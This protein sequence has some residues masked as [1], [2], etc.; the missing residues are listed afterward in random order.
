MTELI[1]FQKYADCIT[2]SGKYLFHNMTVDQLHYFIMNAEDYIP[3]N[4]INMNKLS[5]KN[6]HS[7]KTFTYRSFSADADVVLKSQTIENGKQVFI[8]NYVN[9]LMLG[10]ST[11]DMVW[12]IENAGANKT[13]LTCSGKIVISGIMADRI[14]SEMRRMCNTAIENIMTRFHDQKIEIL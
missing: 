2:V 11:T 4:L 5:I 12:A 9:I 3:H 1:S 8:H 7:R 10:T 13:T 6:E 14:E